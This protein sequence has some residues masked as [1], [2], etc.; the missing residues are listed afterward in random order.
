MILKKYVEKLLGR[1]HQKLNSKMKMKNIL[2]YELNLFMTF[3]ILF[4]FIC[5]NSISFAKERERIAVL[6]FKANNTSISDANIVRNNIELG[7]YKSGYFN[8]LE[9]DS[10]K[11]VL[12][13]QKLIFLVLIHL[14]LEEHGM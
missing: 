6:D 7:L 10:I 14:N 9:R 8:L 3:I 13:E 1:F 4:L 5:G 2:I 12:K 11:L